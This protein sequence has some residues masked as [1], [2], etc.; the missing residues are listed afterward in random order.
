MKVITGLSRKGESVRNAERELIFKVPL[1]VTV[2]SGAVL[3][4]FI[5]GKV[6]TQSVC[7]YVEKIRYTTSM[8]AQFTAVSLFAVPAA[9]VRIQMKC[10][11]FGGRFG[12]DVNH[13]THCIRPV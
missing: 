11:R 8:Q 13:S 2:H 6:R 9:D 7:L 3:S 5:K 4:A 12:D 10:K 1:T